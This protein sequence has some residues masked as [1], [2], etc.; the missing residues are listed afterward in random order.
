MRYARLLSAMGAAV[1]LLSASVALA[2]PVRDAASKVR[3]DDERTYETDVTAPR[4]TAP[5]RAFS[6]APAPAA[7]AP[8]PAAPAAPRAKAQAP[9]ANTTV[10]SFSYAPS[11]GMT[12]GRM[13]ANNGSNR[14]FR[15]DRKV[16]AAY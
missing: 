9:R 15:A 13:R 8:A 4:Q 12:N 1:A 16:R 11:Y 2:D 6:Y 7:A 10:R 14:M 5:Q 3:S